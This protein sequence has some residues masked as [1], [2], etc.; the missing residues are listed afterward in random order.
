MP[1]GLAP[2]P[3]FAMDGPASNRPRLTTSI[4]PFPDLDEGNQQEGDLSE[5]Q[6]HVDDHWPA[7]IQSEQRE[8]TRC[9]GE[10]RDRG[11]W[12]RE[13]QERRGVDLEAP[14]LLASRPE[15]GS[16]R[17]GAAIEVFSWRRHGLQEAGGG[18][19]RKTIAHHY[20]I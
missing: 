8:S 20:T 11:S 7:P 18:H 9:I 6:N 15:A 10:L 12:E 2:P 5:H 14:P 4:L 3:R 1:K 17:K 16:G 13:G 19:I